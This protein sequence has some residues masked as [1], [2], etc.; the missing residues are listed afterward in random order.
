MDIAPIPS[1]TIWKRKVYPIRSASPARYSLKNTTRRLSVP[2]RGRVI[3]FSLGWSRGR[4]QTSAAASMFAHRLSTDAVQDVCSLNATI[5]YT[6]STATRSVTTWP[7]DPLSMTFATMSNAGGLG[8]TTDEVDGSQE[9]WQ[10]VTVDGM[11]TSRRSMK[12]SPI[13][14]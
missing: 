1:S 2:D 9:A 12:G 10:V 6:H 14:W 13:S 3:G 4:P 5:Q 8:L 11:L 7:M